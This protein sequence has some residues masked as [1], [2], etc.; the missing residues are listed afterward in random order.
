MVILVSN[1]GSTSLKFKLFDM[2][3]ET[4]LCEGRV[5]RVGSA[6]G[7]VYHYTNPGR[8]INIKEEKQ[9]IPDYSRGI[10]R[11]LDSLRCR[12]TGP[13]KAAGSGTT[14]LEDIAA[15]GFKTVL[16][17]GFYGVHLLDEAVL[18][19]MEDYRFVAPVHN[20]A[21]LEAIARFREQLPGAQ[22]VG[23]F[24]TAFHTTIPVERRIYALPYEWY[25]KYGIQRMGYH[26]ASHSYI[27]RTMAGMEAAGAGGTAARRIISCHLGGSC[28]I[29]AILDGKSVDNSFGF[30]LQAGVP[31]ANRTGDLDPYIV[32][33]LLHEGMSMEELLEG[34]EKNGGMMGISGLSNDMR[35]L[36]EAACGGGHE[37]AKLAL[38]IF[39]NAVQRYIGQYYVELGGLDALVFTGGI[40]EN[41][42]FLR[43][44][45]GESVQSLGIELDDEA[46]AAGMDANG[47]NANGTRGR[48]ISSPASKAAV[49]VIAANEELGVARESYKLLQCGVHAV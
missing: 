39:V 40:G 17:R 33:Y 14:G 19:A 9:N 20:G 8:G 11:F 15:V 47:R 6:G 27:A 32:L 44:R 28:S 26:G 10:R 49:W 30:S 3:A 5:E 18:R 48:L 4:V 13:V 25:E 34:L 7:A 2:P 29:C 22:M 46:N 45:I 12:E 36:E 41:S 43:R 21:Y 31:H 16:A 1:A 42:P 37:R 35:D 24:E 38:D 23:V